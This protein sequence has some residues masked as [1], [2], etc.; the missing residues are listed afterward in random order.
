[1]FS[2]VTDAEVIRQAEQTNLPTS[3]SFYYLDNLK[4]G[5]D[6]DIE[7]LQV[8]VNPQSGEQHNVIRTIGAQLMLTL[9]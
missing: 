2:R 3:W 8:Q 7:R 6:V 5:G 1:M 9:S 4:Q